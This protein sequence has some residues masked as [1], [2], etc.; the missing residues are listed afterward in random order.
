M[1]YKKM[2]AL[3]FYL[4]PVRL[5]PIFEFEML[6]EEWKIIPNSNLI[7]HLQMRFCIV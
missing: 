3:P 2:T 5:F 7:W 4:G 6:E 1:N